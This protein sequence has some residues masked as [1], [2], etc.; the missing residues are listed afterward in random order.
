MSRS[1]AMSKNDE[2]DTGLQTERAAGTASGNVRFVI[3]DVAAYDAEVHILQMRLNGFEPIT[4][5]FVAEY[6]DNRFTRKQFCRDDCVILFYFRKATLFDRLPP[7][8]PAQA[9]H[10][11]DW[12]CFEENHTPVNYGHARA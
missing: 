7:D 11:H 4:G 12:L 6:M 8:F 2:A 9:L 3:S 5:R 10:C 1:G